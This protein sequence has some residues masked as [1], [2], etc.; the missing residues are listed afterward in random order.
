VIA[1][2]IVSQQDILWYSNGAVAGDFDGGHIAFYEKGS[3]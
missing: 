2:I 1:A 3:A